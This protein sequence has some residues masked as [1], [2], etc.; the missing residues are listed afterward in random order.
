[1]TAA[2]H[3]T[4][5]ELALRV[6]RCEKTIKNWRRDN[7]GP[8]YMQIGSTILYPVAWVEAWEQARRRKTPPAA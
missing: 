5:A 1:M 4:T 7:L 3:L 6:R 8:D 2:R